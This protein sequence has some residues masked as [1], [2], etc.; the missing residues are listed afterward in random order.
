MF[1][2]NYDIYYNIYYF[3]FF[4]FR[5]LFFVCM[6]NWAGGTW[7][8]AVHY[9][10]ADVLWTVELSNKRGKEVLKV[11]QFFFQFYDHFLMILIHTPK[12]NILIIALHKLIPLQKWN[13]AACC[14]VKC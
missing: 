14:N 7:S 12:S 4:F 13:I 6:E 8:W 1:I 2:I 5:K 3:F 11:S 10:W 9:I